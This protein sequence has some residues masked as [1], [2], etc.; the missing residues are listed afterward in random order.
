[1]IYIRFQ[2]TEWTQYIPQGK[3]AGILQQTKA[4]QSSKQSRWESSAEK[5][6]V[7]VTSKNTLTP[8]RVSLIYSKQNS[9]IKTLRFRR[10]S[11]FFF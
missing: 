6:V 3:E 5:D 1:M 9:K 4:V 11:I 2:G 8:V 7:L 10:H